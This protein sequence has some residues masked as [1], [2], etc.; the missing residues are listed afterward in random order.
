MGTKEIQD[1]SL[2]VFYFKFK[3]QEPSYSYLIHILRKSF[4][5]GFEFANTLKVLS[6][7]F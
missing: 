5:Y 7:E 2:L 6:S 1:I 3:F 4:G